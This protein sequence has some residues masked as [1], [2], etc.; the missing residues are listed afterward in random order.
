MKILGI[1]LAGKQENPSG[2]AILDG[3]KMDLLTIYTNKEIFDLVDELKPYVT[4]IDAPLSLPKGRCCLEKDCKCAIGGHFR[5]AERDIRQ[6]GRVLPLT[7]S[8]MKMLTHRGI[9]LSNELKKQY[10]VLESHPHTNMKI[11]KLSEPYSGLNKFFDISTKANEHEL[12]AGLLA[13]TGY[14]YLNNCCIELGDP[15]E[16]MIVI[17]SSEKCLDILDVLKKLS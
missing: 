2:I 13:L 3:N 1:D 8:G 16:G 17:P 6:Y 4:I 12:D 11:L 5:Q 15:D 10:I 9:K 14:L 7:F